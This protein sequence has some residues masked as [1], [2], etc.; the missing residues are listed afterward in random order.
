MGHD[1]VIHVLSDL[2]RFADQNELPLLREQLDEAMI[3]AMLEIADQSGRSR[4]MPKGLPGSGADQ[5]SD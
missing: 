2:R 4:R 1:W 5:I 3:T